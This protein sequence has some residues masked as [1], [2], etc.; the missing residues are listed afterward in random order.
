MSA[1]YDCVSL[2]IYVDTR[3]LVKITKMTGTCRLCLKES[4]KLSP[5]FCNK[6]GR[7]HFFDLYRKIFICCGIEINEYDELSSF[8]CN[9]CVTKLNAAYDFRLVCQ[10]SNS[11]YCQ[12]EKH[13][14]PCD[15]LNS[16]AEVDSSKVKT[17]RKIC[18]STKI[19]QYLKVAAKSNADTKDSNKNTATINNNV[20]AVQVNGVSK[21]IADDNQVNGLSVKNADGK[22]DDTDVSKTGSSNLNKNAGDKASRV[23]ISDESSGTDDGTEE[24]SYEQR[25]EMARIK[26]KDILVLNRLN[27][28]PKTTASFMNPTDAQ[29]S[30]TTNDKNNL[31]K[32][33][34]GGD[35]SYF[36]DGNVKGAQVDDNLNNNDNLNV[37]ENANVPSKDKL[38]E[39]IKE[40][41]KLSAEQNFLVNNDKD[42]IVD[43]Q[44]KEVDHSFD[45]Q[46]EIVVAFDD[47]IQ[48]REE[49]AI[50]VND[51][52]NIQIVI[53][54]RSLD[55]IVEEEE[56]DDEEEERLAADNLTDRGQ[57]RVEEIVENVVEE[58]E[59][60]EDQAADNEK[61]AE[62]VATDDQ[63]SSTD[64]LDSS[65]AK[66]ID[67]SIDKPNKYYKNNPQVPNNDNVKISSK[68]KKSTSRKRTR[69]NQPCT[70]SDKF[71][72]SDDDTPL[73]D[74]LNESK[75][76]R[77][78]EAKKSSLVLREDDHCYVNQEDKSAKSSSNSIE[79]EVE[80]HC[81]RD[82]TPDYPVVSSKVNGHV[83]VQK[84]VPKEAVNKS[85]SQNFTK[86]I[87]G[88]DK[89]SIDYDQILDVQD[90]IAIEVAHN[91][92]ILP[93]N[94]Q[95]IDYSVGIPDDD[96]QD[97][98]DDTQVPK[99]NLEVASSDSDD[100]VNQDK[101][102]QSVKGK[103]ITKS[104]TNRGDDGEENFCDGQLPKDNVKKSKKKDLNKNKK[105]STNFLVIKKNVKS[106]TKVPKNKFKKKKDTTKISNL[107]K[108]K[109]KPKTVRQEFDEDSESKKKNKSS[110]NKKKL[111]KKPPSS[112]DSYQ[113]LDSEADSSPEAKTT[114]N[115]DSDD[116]SSDF[117][118]FKRSRPLRF[119][120]FMPESSI[121]ESVRNL[122][123]SKRRKSTPRRK[124]TTGR[125]DQKQ[126][127]KYCGT[128]YLY[129]KPLF[130]HMKQRHGIDSEDLIENKN[131][132]VCQKFTPPSQI[133]LTNCFVMLNR[134]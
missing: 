106:S 16:N 33:A 83:K 42:K 38:G 43:A 133:P 31:E 44:V 88:L 1:S 47:T 28:P 34:D 109:S 85:K 57:N 66:D 77:S 15:C 13:T 121:N 46:E 114:T 103:K 108:S 97:S 82:L 69:S 8:I 51:P 104:M 127:C 7:E 23:S 21:K 125:M 36:I 99:N 24:L 39:A 55:K 9:D 96:L 12:L 120:S 122:N 71:N 72:D 10:R 87:S 25:I 101:K 27:I 119:S 67:T 123:D 32:D 73:A 131:V 94:A 49:I 81:T 29:I 117:I 98:S 20:E 126:V 5:I 91:I 4:S 54:K 45:V 11:S 70:V 90:D 3:V 128:S 86:I 116:D 52:C 35:K 78:A 118:G 107:K 129:R 2:E 19:D 65:V 6:Q 134:I 124:S 62:E 80:V 115:L 61:T 40:Q 50:E 89:I 95:S 84:D 112:D 110:K 68:D 79:V 100:E 58:E 105:T 111:K 63:D 102:L 48:V 22:K 30:K 18:E 64:D 59:V 93:E 130:K 74:K 17:I 26:Y 37:N 75:R 56:E 14:D 53:P 41:I 113:D 132:I 92:E 60:N 76:R